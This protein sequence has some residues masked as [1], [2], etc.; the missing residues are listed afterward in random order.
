[1]AQVVR[2]QPFAMVARF[3]L[4][5]VYVGFVVVKV[6]VGHSALSVLFLQCSLH[7]FHSFTIDAIYNVIG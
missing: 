7:T 5:Q 2:Y 6:S 4:R 1:M 3:S